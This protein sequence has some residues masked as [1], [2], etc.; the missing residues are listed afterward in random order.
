MIAVRRKLLINKIVPQISKLMFVSL[1]KKKQNNIDPTPS[2][3]KKD[4]KKSRK[5][6]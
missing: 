3:S 1:N 4:N 2:E 6:E 5:S